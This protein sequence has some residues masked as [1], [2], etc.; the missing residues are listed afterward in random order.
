MD[1]QFTEEQNM[2]RDVMRKFTDKE[3]RPMAEKIDKEKIVPVGILKKAGE[4]GLLGLPFPERYGGT[5]AGEIGYCMLMEEIS[6]ACASTTVTLGAHIGLASAAIYLAGSEEQKQK[7]LVPLIR[8]EK[9]GAFSLTEPQAGSDAGHIQTLAVP[10]GEGFRINGSKLWTTNGDVADVVVVFAVTDP[11]LGPKGGVTAFLVE[12]GMSGFTVGK[13]EDKMGL[14]GSSTAEL[15]FQDVRVPKANILG[16]VGSGF[17]TAMKTLDGGRLSL[18]AGCVGAS[19]EVIALSI[20]FAKKRVQFGQ[21][22]AHFEAIQWMIADMTAETYAC[23]SIVYRTAWMA[24]QGMKISR[25]SAICKL[26]AS[27]MLDRNVDKAL[28]IHGGMGYMTDYPIE[29]F[30]RDA[31]INRIFEG[32]NEIQRLVIAED[33]IKKGSY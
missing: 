22:I 28:Q 13:I 5:G 7:V 20:E 3:V 32:T 4:L 21:P 11:K 24:D 19:K 29:R 31:R 33:V 9:I 30:Y 10:D 16:P 1:F 27:E 23:E 17:V 18:A 2:L 8:G 26:M 14:R 15:I 6:H 25:E 12:K